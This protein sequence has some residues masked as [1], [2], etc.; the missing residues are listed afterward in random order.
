MFLVNPIA[1]RIFF[2]QHPLRNEHF[3]V[4][5][6]SKSRA[7]NHQMQA[8][9]A[10]REWAV[11]TNSILAFL[12]NQKAL[13][14]LGFSKHPAD[15][16]AFSEDLALFFRLLVKAASHRAW[17]MLPWSET[18]PHCWAGILHSNLAIAKEV[19]ERVKG[20]VSIVQK[21]WET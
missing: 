5:E 6:L 11:T 3:L 12:S 19:L 1:L 16:S 17:N 10:A 18:Q 20:D 14:T 9:W 4:M 7:G 2:S 13:S 15:A 8:A 21:A